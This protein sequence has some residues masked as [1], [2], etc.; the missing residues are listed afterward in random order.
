MGPHGAPWDFDFSMG[1][2]GRPM[3]SSGMNQR[4]NP[5][6]KRENFPEKGRGFFICPIF[7]IKINNDKKIEINFQG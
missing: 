5:F 4:K 6:E 2:H 7:D 3:Q 1:P